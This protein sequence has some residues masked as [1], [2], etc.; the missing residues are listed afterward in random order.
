MR[1]QD[2]PAYIIKM[3]AKPGSGDRLFELATEGMK[4]SGASDRFIIVREDEDPDVLW[5]VEVF[6]SDEAKAAYENSPLADTLRDEIIDLLAEP[7][8]RVA[9]HPYSAAPD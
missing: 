6:N 3:R 2:R 5:N 7:P 9:V 1:L 4:K 8:M